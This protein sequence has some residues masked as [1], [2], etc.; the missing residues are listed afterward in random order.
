MKELASEVY[1]AMSEAIDEVEKD[2][3]YRP[4][5]FLGIA[6]YPDSIWTITT[7]LTTIA[8][9]LFQANYSN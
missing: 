6:L 1:D 7:F 2:M 9:G 8:F 3:T 5:K 4:Q